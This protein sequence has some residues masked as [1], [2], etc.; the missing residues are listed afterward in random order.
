M[1]SDL[2]GDIG[3]LPTTLFRNIVVGPGLEYKFQDL[4]EGAV[5]SSSG[6]FSFVMQKGLEIFAAKSIK[7][8]DWL[9][10]FGGRFGNNPATTKSRIQP[11]CSQS[12]VGPSATIVLILNAFNKSVMLQL[13]QIHLLTNTIRGKWL[14]S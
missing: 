10:Y 8:S 11:V 14:V 3:I 5:C 13:T 9:K 12:M 2:F 7:Q 4:N 1:P 6:E